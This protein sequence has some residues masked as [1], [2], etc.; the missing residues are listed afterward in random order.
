MAFSEATACV[1]HVDGVNLHVANTGDSRAML[2][3]QEEDGSGPQYEFLVLA[4][5]GL[6]EIMH[7]QDVV[8]IV[9]EY[10][11]GMVTL[12]QMH[13]L[14]TE[15]RAKMFSVFKDQNAA[16]HLF[17]HTVGNNEFGTVDHERLSKMLSLPEELARMYRADITIVVHFNSHVVGAYQN[18]E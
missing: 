7:R 5:D 15:R 1:A 6:W 2:G 14:L 9:G 10:L 4:T 3:V 8:R 17:R 11:N 12:G 16:T 18:H 13:V